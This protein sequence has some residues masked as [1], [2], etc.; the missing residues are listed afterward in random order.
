[1]FAFAATAKIGW[2]PLLHDPRLEGLLHRVKAKTLC[3]WGANDRLVPLEYGEKF[4][5]LIPGATLEVIPA[6]GHM[7]P[8]EKQ[9]EWLAAVRRFLG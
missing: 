1:M 9:A 2:N 7:V 6:C 3:V 8:F 4:A 5:K